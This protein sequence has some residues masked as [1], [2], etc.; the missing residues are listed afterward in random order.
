MKAEALVDTLSDTLPNAEA[1]TGEVKMGNVKAETVADTLIEVD[2]ATFFI[3][4]C[5]LHGEVPWRGTCLE[6]YLMQRTRHLATYCAILRQILVHRQTDTVG[7]ARRNSEAVSDK[8]GC[9]IVEAKNKTDSNTFGY[10]ERKELVD[11][12]ADPL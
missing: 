5:D 6:R 12:L 8:L 4:L 7:D 10:V 3:T 11:T 9:T 1:E 2:C